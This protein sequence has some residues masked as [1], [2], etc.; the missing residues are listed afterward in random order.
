MTAL[1]AAVSLRP[2]VHRGNVSTL[3]VLDLDY[4][5]RILAF[6]MSRA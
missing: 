5:V 1:L 4:A 2:K 6:L 3:Q